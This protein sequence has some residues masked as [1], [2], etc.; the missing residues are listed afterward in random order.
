MFISEL[1][2]LTYFPISIKLSA[3]RYNVIAAVVRNVG[4][5]RASLLHQ[6]V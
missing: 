5:Q 3:A 2:K 4:A 1:W 6:K